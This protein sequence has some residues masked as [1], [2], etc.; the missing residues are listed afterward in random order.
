MAIAFDNEND[1][2]FRRPVATG[3]ETCIEHQVEELW[4][5]DRD[6]HAYP[7]LRSRN[8][9]VASLHEPMAH[10]QRT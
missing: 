5:L 3:R 10:Y 7:D 1:H 2:Q 9:L 4:T 6:F 8:P